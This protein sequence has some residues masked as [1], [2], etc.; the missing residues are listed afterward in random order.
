L[1]KLSREHPRP[2]LKAGGLVAILAFLD[3]FPSGV[4]RSAVTAASN[5][6][7]SVPYDCLHQVVDAL[8]ALT[9]L[10]RSQ[11]HKIVEKTV[12]CFA[13]FAPL[14]YPL[15]K[16]RITKEKIY[17]TLIFFPKDLQT[18]FQETQTIYRQLQAWKCFVI[19]YVLQVNSSSRKAQV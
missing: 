10:L 9:G 4:Q 13:R 16:L 15:P 2:I 18:A 11:D 6:C 8:P 12:L 5:I 17:L 19:W 3:F 7:K 1:E 14:I